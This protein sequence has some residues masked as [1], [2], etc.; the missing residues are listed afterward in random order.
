MICPHIAAN[1]VTV[2][3]VI[4]DVNAHLSVFPMLLHIPELLSGY[5][6]S[7]PWDLHASLSDA[8]REEKLALHIFEGGLALKTNLCL[9]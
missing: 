1:L 5:L 2:F 3:E 8:Y 7:E 4:L 6:E 9:C